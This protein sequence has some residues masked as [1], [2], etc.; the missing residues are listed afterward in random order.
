MTNKTE[1]LQKVL[2]N[3]IDGKKVFGTSFCLNYQSNEWCGASGNLNCDS[4]FFIASTTKLY[5]TA[6]LLHLKSN[7]LLSL[8][9]TIDKYLD[10]SILDGLHLLNGKDNASKITIK[11]LMAHTSGLPDYFQQKTKEGKSFEKEL[12]AGNDKYWSFNQAIAHSKTLQPHFE[13]NKK[14]KAHYSDTNFQLLGKIIE[15]ITEKSLNENYD[16]I[17]FRPL[18]L[19][20]TYLYSDINDKQPKPF[21]YKTKELHIPKAM[22]SFGADGGIVSTADELLKFLKAFFEGRFFPIS[23]IE[24]LKVW[25]RIFFPMQSGVGIHLFKLPWLFN[26]FGTVPELIGHSGLS[27]TLAYYSPEKNLFIAGT[28]NQVAYPDTSFKLAIKLIQKMLSKD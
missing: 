4:Q 12:I 9:D 13:P 28:V 8:D 7:Q 3:A 22:T 2:E 23:Y 6:I 15:T 1:K 27:G 5:V 17:I 21:Y 10:Q 26:P 11:N 16:S 18:G 14:G 25:N 20:K 19:S 24:D